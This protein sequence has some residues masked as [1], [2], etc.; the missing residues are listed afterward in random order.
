M[1]FIDSGTSVSPTVFARRSL[2]YLANRQLQEAIGDA[3][4]AQV[5]F[6]QWPIA[7]YLQAAVLFSLGM[8]RDAQQALQHGATL[9]AKMNS[10][11]MHV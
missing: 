3:M 9:E 2:S 8:E 1:Q 4:Q 11:G 5:V 7:H 6:P 10:K